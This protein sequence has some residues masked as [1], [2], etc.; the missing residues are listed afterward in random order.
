M[1]AQ[2]TECDTIRQQ[3]GRPTLWAVG[4][5][6]YTIMPESEDR[7]VGLRFTVNRSRLTK[8][9]ID[10]SWNDTYEVSFLRVNARTGVAKVI[11]SVS[12]VH[13]PELS[14]VVYDLSCRK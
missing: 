11:E 7:R 9:Q 5:R 14:E 6:D 4:A 2:Y 10:L 3:V 12:D 8:I 1:N 13:F